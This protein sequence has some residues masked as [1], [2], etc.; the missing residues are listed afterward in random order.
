[1]YRSRE[2]TVRFN[3]YLTLDQKRKLEWLAKR[4][5]VSVGE[6]IRRGVELKLKEGKS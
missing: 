3:F 1:M 4:L 5:K 6:V 2:A